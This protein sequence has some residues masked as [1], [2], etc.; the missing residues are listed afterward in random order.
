MAMNTLIGQ[1]IP[2][3]G[4]KRTQV[5]Q[6]THYEGGNRLPLMNRSFISFNYD[7]HWCEDMGV[8]ATI[9][10]DMMSKSIYGNFNDVVSD[11]EGVDGQLYWSTHFTNNTLSF[12]LSTDAV[13]ERQLDE[14]KRWLKPGKIAPLVLAENPNREILARISDNPPEYNMLPFEQKEKIKLGGY[15]YT[16]STTVYRGS[17]SVTFIMDEP[18]W[19]AK[20]N[21]LDMD[22]ILYWNNANDNRSEIIKDKD[23]LKIILEDGIPFGSVM[24]ENENMLYGVPK[25]YKEASNDPGTL[26]IVG[27]AKVGLAKLGS[28]FHSYDNIENFKF[29][30]GESQA[31]YFYYPG[32]APSAPTLKFK[33][34]PVFDLN[35]YITM[36]N[37][38]YSSLNNK[39]YNTIT[40]EGYNK[41]ELHLTTP[42]VYTAYN[43]AI[44]IVK[45]AVEGQSNINNKIKIDAGELRQLLRDGVNHWAVRSYAIATFDRIKSTAQEGED[46]LSSLIGEMKGFFTDDSNELTSASFV[47]NCETGEALGTF[48]YRVYNAASTKSNKFEITEHTE[49]VGDM[50]LSN[51]FIIEER[52]YFSEDGFI[53]AW[54]NEHKNYSHRIYHDFGV[55]SNGELVESE[56]G[57]QDFLIEYRYYYY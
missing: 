22:K 34:T 48:K 52:N 27:K 2:Q 20:K 31:Q 14:I 25:K 47:I 54:S 55:M 39:G 18:F 53:R 42:T 23:A 8:I 30:G 29:L 10:G 38:S 9:D 28:W 56:M 26:P 13:T 4:P 24:L 16:T 46:W 51:N 7:N 45:Q 33:L 19:H 49:Q 5:W 37:N 11:L 41:K 6:A 15:E 1:E 17:F 21:I 57:L 43:Q 35:G 44:A 40:I 12:T 32:T 3:T 36:P 50:I